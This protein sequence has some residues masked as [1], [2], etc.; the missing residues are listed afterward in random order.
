MRDTKKNTYHVCSALRERI[1]VGEPIVMQN[2]LVLRKYPCTK[3]D[4]TYYRRSYVIQGYY[5]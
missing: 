5:R 3:A 2:G 1:T 4:D